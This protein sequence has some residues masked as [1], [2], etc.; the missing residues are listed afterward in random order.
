VQITSADRIIAGLAAAY[1]SYRLIS[2]L[3]SGIYYGDGDMDV[4]ASE[5]P[6]A[7]ALAALSSVLLIGLCTYL[8]LGLD[9]REISAVFEHWKRFGGGS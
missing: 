7:F 2:G 5:H 1:F 6:L 4:D 8:A 9:A 3:K